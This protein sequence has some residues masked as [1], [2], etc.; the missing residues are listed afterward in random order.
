MFITHALI[1]LN[2]VLFLNIDPISNF[3]NSY[4]LLSPYLIMEKGEIERLIF[5]NISHV[6]LFHLYVNMI[7]LNYLG[8]YFERNLTTKKYIKLLFSLGLISSLL[9]CL[10]ALICK[11][12][13]DYIDFYYGYSKGFSCIIF[14]LSYLYQN[15][16][17]IDR[18][19]LGFSIPSQYVIWAQLAIIRILR[20]SSNLLGH[21]CG[22]IAGYLNSFNN[23]K[24]CSLSIIICFL[25]T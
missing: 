7:S 6:N 14:G 1:L 2:I 19:I 13:F 21:L 10:I 22:I 15:Q 5:H 24:S 18:L 4:S 9:Y 8:M 3:I 20:P 17:N 16:T 25:K 11:I 23:G 12:C